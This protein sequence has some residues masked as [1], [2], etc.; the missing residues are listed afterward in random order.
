LDRQNHGGPVRRFLNRGWVLAALLA[1]CVGLITWGMWPLSAE[2]LFERGSAL[3]Q[4]DDPDDW[5]RGWRDY[6]EPLAKK[7]PADAEAHAGGVEECR[8]KVQQGEGGRARRQALRNARSSRRASEAQWFFQQGL[9][10]RQQ[11]DEAGAR[12]VWEGLVRL[13]RDVESERGWVE[14]AR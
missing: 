11:G 4:S 12:R 6:L 8:Q 14:L 10:L 3:M 13:F 7:H 5:E 9:R 2:Q 1:V